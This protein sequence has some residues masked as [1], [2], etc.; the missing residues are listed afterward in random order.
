MHW[1]I[2][3]HILN[4]LQPYTFQ[5]SP[6]CVFLS[7][8]LGTVTKLCPMCTRPLTIDETG[9]FIAWSASK[10]SVSGRQKRP[11][12]N[13]ATYGTFFDLKRTYT[14]PDV[15]FTTT[16][17]DPPPQPQPISLGPHTFFG[18]LGAWLPFKQTL[19]GEEI[20]ELRE[21]HLKSY[22]VLIN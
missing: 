1:L 4:I 17:K 8:E 3:C 2:R 9:D 22:L 10:G 21:C 11:H 7:L 16:R 6:L 19:S 12:I 14:P 15:D 18:G 5:V 20:D 13:G